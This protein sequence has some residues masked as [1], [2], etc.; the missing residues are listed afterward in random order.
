MNCCNI[1]TLLYFNHTS[2][3]DAK[4]NKLYIFAETKD[5]TNFSSPSLAKLKMESLNILWLI[6]GVL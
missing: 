1:G 6:V 5:L 4:D 2:Q 3:N